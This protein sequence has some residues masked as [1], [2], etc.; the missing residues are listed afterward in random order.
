MGLQAIF[1]IVTDWPYI[2]SRHSTDET[3]DLIEDAAEYVSFFPAVPPPQL[4]R[5][6]WCCHYEADL[7]FSNWKYAYRGACSYYEMFV[8]PVLSDSERSHT[9]AILQAMFWHGT[10]YDLPQQ[11]DLALAR[12]YSGYNQDVLVSI[13][14]ANTRRLGAALDVLLHQFATWDLQGSFDNTNFSGA[15]CTFG[16][17]LAYVKNWQ[18]LFKQANAQSAGIIIEAC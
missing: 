9:D 4:H 13:N 7:L 8:R 5:P 3:M 6:E 16:A 15:L 12:V 2:A 10:E 14:P 18:S 1:L 11:S 17:W